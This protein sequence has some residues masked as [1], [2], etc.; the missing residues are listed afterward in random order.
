MFLSI[1]FAWGRFHRDSNARLC[2]QLF[3]PGWSSVGAFWSLWRMLTGFS[4][5]IA[6]LREAAY[7]DL[8]RRQRCCN[9]QAKPPRPHPW[10]AFRSPQFPCIWQ[11][12]GQYLW[13]RCAPKPDW[14]SCRAPISAWGRGHQTA[15]WGGCSSRCRQWW[16][17][18]EVSVQE[19]E[20]VPDTFLPEEKQEEEWLLKIFLKMLSCSRILS[21]LTTRMYLIIPSVCF[22]VFSVKSRT[23]NTLEL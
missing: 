12:R 3:T 21:L 14:M 18:W 16:V 9:F 1:S 7:P 8:Q 6:L 19:E 13:Q 5:L 2:M 15:G 11:R 22:F 23:S 10:W 20:E 4:L 17:P